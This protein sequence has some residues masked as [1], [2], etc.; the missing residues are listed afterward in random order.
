MSIGREHT[1]NGLTTGET[2]AMSWV[3]GK[4]MECMACDSMTTSALRRRAEKTRSKEP[5]RPLP[6][7]R[8]V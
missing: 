4:A 1:Y 8:R 6:A 7:G 5:D 3:C 2:A